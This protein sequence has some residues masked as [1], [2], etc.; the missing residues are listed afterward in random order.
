MRTGIKVG[1]IM[2]R[3]FASIKPTSSIIDA[4]KEMIKK[5]VG[6]LVV[7]E[8]KQLRGILTERD[9]I[10]AMIKKSRVELNKISVMDIAKRKVHTIK[11]S[12]DL[13]IALQKMKDTGYRRLPVLVKKE[14]IGVLTLK[15]ILRVQPELFE[16][17]PEIM[18]IKEEAEK[19]KRIQKIREGKIVEGICEECGAFDILHNINNKLVCESCKHSI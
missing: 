11:P 2:T 17:A 3:N 4:S 7:M 10:W 5:R 13:T 8:G 12:A 15:D 19:F 6:S 9:I 14:V 18:N 1:D 16:S